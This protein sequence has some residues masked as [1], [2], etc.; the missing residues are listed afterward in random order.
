MLAVARRS[1]PDAEIIDEMALA[2][3]ASPAFN[4]ATAF[5]L[6]R[7]ADLS[8]GLATITDSTLSVKGT[9]LTAGGL[10]RVAPGVPQGASERGH[11]WPGRYHAGA[12]RS[13]RL[14]GK[15]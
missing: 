3:G 13:L 10:C 2:R 1:F 12:G 8:E 7:V 9:A 5:A 6:D 11:A 4:A 15:L 14:V